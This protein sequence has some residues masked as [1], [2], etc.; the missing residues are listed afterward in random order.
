MPG[1]GGGSPCLPAISA[2][3]VGCSAEEVS[4]GISGKIGST[5]Q[6]L[7]QKLLN[8]LVGVVCLKISIEKQPSH[9]QTLDYFV[10]GC[11]TNLR[12]IQNYKFS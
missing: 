11:V 2:I 5:Y 8:L 3:I 12:V 10:A 6:W 9:N 1:V 7:N 4:A